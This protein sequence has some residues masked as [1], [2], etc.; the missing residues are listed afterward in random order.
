VTPLLLLLLLLS[1]HR[2]LVVRH[3]TDNARDDK[4]RAVKMRAAKI[5]YT[6]TPN[7][8]L[9]AVSVAPSCREQGTRE[10]T[11]INPLESLPH[12]GD[13]VCG[14]LLDDQRE[15]RQLGRRA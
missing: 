3:A 13:G 6:P 1:L 5:L 12:I 10:F 8:M 11:L 7:E 2:G 14:A 9:L 15:W 4:N